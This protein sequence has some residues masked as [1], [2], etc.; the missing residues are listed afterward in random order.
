MP[1]NPSYYAAFNSLFAIRDENALNGR[2]ETDL[3]LSLYSSTRF[4][5]GQ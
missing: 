1:T 4:Y 2:Y 5:Y 3:G